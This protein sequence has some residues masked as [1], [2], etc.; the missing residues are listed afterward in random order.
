MFKS[1]LIMQNTRENGER[2]KP[3]EEVNFGTQMAIS[4]KENGKMTKPMATVFTS[5]LMEPNTKDTGKTIFK[6]VKVWNPGKT[7]ADTKVATKKA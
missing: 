1:G 2:T 6:M 7:V 3:T 4:T 5:T